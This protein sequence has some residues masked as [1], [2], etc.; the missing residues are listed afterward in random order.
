M[1]VYGDH[2][3]ATTLA[4]LH[5]AAAARL[6]DA[7]AASRG[8]ARHGALVATFVAWAELTR[9]AADA[10]FAEHGRDRADPSLDAAMAVLV[11]PARAVAVSWRSRFRRTPLPALGPAP[12]ERTVTTKSAQVFAFYALYPEAV[13]EAAARLAPARDT[14]ILCLRVIGTALAAMVAA[15]LRSPEGPATLRPVGH[16]F[17]RRIVAAPPTPSARALVVDEGPGLSGSSLAAAVS[18]LGSSGTPPRHVTLLTSHPHLPR[19]MASPD[20]LALWRGCGRCWAD[21]EATILPRLPYWVASLLGEPFT[22]WQDLSAGAWTRTLPTDPPRKRRKYLAT[23]ATRRYLVKFAGLGE[24]GAAKLAHAH[25][26]AALS[27]VPEPIG[28]AHGFLVERWIE[29]RPPAVPTPAELARYLAARAALA[30]P[31]PSASLATL[32]AMAHANIA[33]AL[34]SGAAAAFAFAA[35][36]SG[37]EATPGNAVA[38]DARL[39]AW[40]WLRDANGHLLKADALDHCEGHDLIGYQDI[41]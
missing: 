18:W 10:A 31:N 12:A 4:V 41:A 3:R 7:R 40:E 32:I 23:T 21:F 8:L 19:A 37:M 5:A 28:L 11:R 9:A 17:A 2:P 36:V 1:I 35:R 33:E 22:A 20:T 38:V 24:I 27:L 13:F 6:S 30:P 26:N 29:P 34:G 15:A 39:H 16:P 25:A 14:R